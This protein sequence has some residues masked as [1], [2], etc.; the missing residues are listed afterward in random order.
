[1]N[2]LKFITSLRDL[3]N[4]LNTITIV[5]VLSLITA[6]GG[7]GG[8]ET[9]PPGTT[10]QPVDV[11][12]G[13]VKGPLVNAIVTAYSL[14]TGKADFKGSVVDTATTDSNAAIT[15][16]TLP[17]PV[18]PP[19]ILEFTSQAGTTDLTTGQFP[20]ITT[21]HTVVTQAMLD[22]GNNIY[23]SPLTTVVVDIAIANTVDSNGTPGI[24]TDEFESALANAAAEVISTLG[25]GL[26]STVDIFSVP[27][28]I[29][30]TT[31]TPQEQT[32]IL[33][34]RKAIEAVTAI[35]FEINQQSGAASVD[36]VL[37]E[38][39]ADLA[40]GGVI[41][42]SA[43]SSINTNTLQVFQQDPDTLP[44][45]NSATNQTVADVYLILAGETAVTAPGTNVD[46]LQNGTIV[47]TTAPAETNAD[48][49]G[50]GIFNSADSTP[51]T[52]TDATDTD[53]DGVFDSVD[54]DPNDPAV[55]INF[56]PVLV[57][58]SITIAEDS[59]TASINVTAN[60]SDNDGNPNDSITLIQVGTASL[61][62]AVING[63]NVDYTP[64]Q[65]AFGT[66][67]FSY[68][69][70][71]GIVSS[72]GTVTVTITPQNVPPGFDSTPSLS[73]LEGSGYTYN[74]FVSDIDPSDTLTI[75][76]PTLP[77]WLNLDTSNFVLSG[78]P[79]SGDVGP[80]AVVL[81]LSDGTANVPAK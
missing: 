60:D 62:N 13:G 40:D 52:G 35:V 27:P 68:T 57:D 21:M 33:A 47:A 34:Y 36:D 30:A 54:L 44:I 23:A 79:G 3:F 19:Y 16:L 15:G 17:T 4:S 20:V 74:I 78:T 64:N 53:G 59:G 29:N 14:D 6:C 63:N 1:M 46:G 11:N 2:R 58:D 37:T 9:T 81:N 24:Q 65:N 80:N 26:D 28:V 8:G 69:V 67:I 42:G 43:G 12:G 31:V 77:A 45:P 25:F 48:I 55:T 39:A 5:F 38:L 32:N 18:T 72:T 75:S 50:D 22:A 51:G 73:A 7:G 71:D 56:A 76:A 10:A 61:G 70:S 41:D 49:D 66:D